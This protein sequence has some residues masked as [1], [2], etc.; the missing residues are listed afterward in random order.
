ME[1]N[2]PLHATLIGLGIGAA[3]QNPKLGVGSAMGAYAYM[4]A[5]GHSWPW[6]DGATTAVEADHRGPPAAAVSAPQAAAKKTPEAP[7]V[8]QRWLVTDE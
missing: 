6:A 2:H 4:R 5:Y 8:V 7:V 3:T 1:T